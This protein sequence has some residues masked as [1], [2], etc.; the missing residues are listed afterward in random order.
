MSETRAFKGNLMLYEKRALQQAYAAQ[1][2]L[3]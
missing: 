2:E 1:T 3:R